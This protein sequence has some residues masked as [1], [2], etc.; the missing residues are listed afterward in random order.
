MKKKP[1]LKINTNICKTYDQLFA[2]LHVHC[3][4]RRGPYRAPCLGA[5]QK[6]RGLW[7]LDGDLYIQGGLHKA[8]LSLQTRVGKLKLVCVKETTTVVKHVGKLLA[9]IETSSIS[10]QQFADCFCA[11][12]THQLEFANS[13]LPCK[14][15]LTIIRELKQRQRRRQRERHK[16]EYLVG[17]NNSFARPAWVPFSLLSISLPSSAKLQPEIAKFEVL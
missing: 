16:F 7:E 4:T 5:D 14:G 11:V 8:N 15:R 6:V 13:S 12:H 3:C 2:K 1:W 10:R 17:K 9:R